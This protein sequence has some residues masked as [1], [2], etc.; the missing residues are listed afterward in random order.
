MVSIHFLEHVRNAGSIMHLLKIHPPFHELFS[1]IKYQGQNM[2]KW[3]IG[4]VCS[5]HTNFERRSHFA[6]TIHH[7]SLLSISRGACQF[8]RHISFEVHD[9]RKCRFKWDRVLLP[10]QNSNSVQISRRVLFC[11]Y[12][13][14]PLQRQSDQ[15]QCHIKTY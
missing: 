8:L 9:C 6:E 1:F 7:I 2:P 14:I 4:G 13:I 12:S 11:I 3:P 5:L 15:Y 10:R